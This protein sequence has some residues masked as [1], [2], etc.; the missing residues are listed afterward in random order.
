MANVN[1][2]NANNVAGSYYVDNN[3]IGCGQCCDI[4]SD[5]FAEQDGLMYVKKQ[6]VDADEISACNEAVQSCPVEAIGSDGK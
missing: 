1:D 4:A 2:K 6:P 5:H 3:C